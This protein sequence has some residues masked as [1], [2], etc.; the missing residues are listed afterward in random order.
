MKID[1][2]ALEK[3][4]LFLDYAAR[5]QRTIASNLANSET[6]GYRAQ[7]VK[8]EELLRDAID[9]SKEL[10][11]TSERHLEARPVLSRPGEG[12]DG[13]GDTLGYDGNNVDLDKEMTDL[14][15]NVLKFSVVS[16]LVQ[17]KLQ[18]IRSGIKEGRTQ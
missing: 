11:K 13:N 2:S 3:M 15:E 12:V 7:D 9:G 18:M 5:K 6:P 8:F 16:R 17:H 1:E 10:R 4:K 14:A